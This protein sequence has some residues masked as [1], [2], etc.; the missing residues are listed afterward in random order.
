[1]PDPITGLIAGGTALIGGAVQ[2]KG[3]RESVEEPGKD[4]GPGD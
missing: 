3:R 1:M 4:A 2:A